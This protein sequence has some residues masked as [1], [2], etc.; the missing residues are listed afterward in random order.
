MKKIVYILLLIVMLG[1]LPCCNSILEVKT[2]NAVPQE[3][4]VD[5]EGVKSLIMGVY[6][7]MQE[8][9]FLGRDLILLPDIMGDNCRPAPG[10]SKYL[11]E[12]NF[13]PRHTINIWKRAYKSIGCLN[14]ALYYLS[15]LEENEG[16]A[17]RG[18][19]L[20]LRALHYFYLA[21]VYA[22]APEHL[23]NNFDLCVPLITLPFF[24]S[25]DKSLQQ[26]AFVKRASVEQVWGQII[27]D[28]KLSASLLEGCNNAPFRASLFAAKALLGR[29]Y[30]YM[31]KWKEAARALEEAEALSS[32]EEVLW[33]LHFTTAENLGASSLESAFVSES[34]GENQVAVNEELMA[35]INPSDIRLKK[36]KKIIFAGEY[37][38]STTKFTG[39]TTFGLCDIPLIR[40]AEVKLN[41]IEALAH[42]KE[43]SKAR[44][45]LDAFLKKCG[46]P[47]TEASDTELLEVILEQ[48]RIELAFEG[49]RFFDLKRLGLNILRPSPLPTIPYSDYRVVAPIPS[50][51]LEIN[52]NLIDNPEY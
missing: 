28:I 50:D 44:L 38:W 2:K 39:N 46:L 37:V 51:E 18:E 16:K 15:K 35:L 48:R 8:P 32:G 31:G 26:V 13:T 40:L 27:E 43:Y 36:F 11:Q 6:D 12:Y 10:A 19:A 49:H 20:L 24:N 5:I 34:N 29:C 30:L 23:T 4:V 41:K 47:P 9:E 25:S 1:F 17:L 21:M 52:K 45:S 14:E 33:Q 3:K 42:L 22:R 7:L